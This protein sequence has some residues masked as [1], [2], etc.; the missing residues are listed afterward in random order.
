MD[1]PDSCGEEISVRP[2]PQTSGL[3]VALASS[4][5]LALKKSS[6]SHDV[7]GPLVTLVVID[8]FGRG[9]A[10]FEFCFLV[11]RKRVEYFH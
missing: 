3:T 6:V 8:M 9:G 1:P 11:D 7:T 4:I 10:K 2:V 5:V